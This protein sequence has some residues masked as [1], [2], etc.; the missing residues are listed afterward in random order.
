MIHPTRYHALATPQKHQVDT[1]RNESIRSISSE[2]QIQNSKTDLIE[3]KTVLELRNVLQV[4]HSSSSAPNKE[5][6]K[7]V[8]KRK[9]TTEKN[10]RKTDCFVQ[11]TRSKNISYRIVSNTKSSKSRKQKNIRKNL[12]QIRR[13]L[14][15]LPKTPGNS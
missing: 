13:N 8:L 15:E 11:N 7:E 2:L 1:V 12:Q 4:F 6:Q 10:F 3:R 5:S 9:I 14:R